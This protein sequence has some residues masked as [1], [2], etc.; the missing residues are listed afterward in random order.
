MVVFLL[1]LTSNVKAQQHYH[2]SKNDSIQISLLTCGPGEEVYSLYG[3]TAIRFHDLKNNQDLVVN[4]GMFSFSQRFFILRFVFGLTDYEMGIMPFDAFME[5]YDSEGRWVKEQILNIPLQDKM[6]IAMA[7]EKNYLP[8]NRT[9]RYN[10]FYD[11][12]TTRARDILI[13]NISGNVET[14]D[15]Q[16]ISS[17]YRKEIHKWNG[18]HCWARWGNDLLLGVNAD[19]S[20]D[21]K[22]QQFLPDNLSRDWQTAKIRYADGKVYNFISQEHY[23]IAKNKS[24]VENNA[25]DSNI[26]SPYYLIGVIIVIILLASWKKTKHPLP[27]KIVMWSVWLITGLCGIIITAMIFS[28]HP[29][30]SLNLQILLLNPLNLGMLVPALARN[31]KYNLT[32]L[33]CLVLFIFGG[34]IQSYADGLEYLAFILLIVSQR[35]LLSQLLKHKKQL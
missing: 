2:N 35:D 7:I 14:Q 11:N 18:D 22:E 26:F 4:Y 21:G 13:Q 20:I 30:V 29:T 31:K 8:E 19:R 34:I 27:Y 24:S 1:S 10:Y 3:H 32:I 33:T 5:E 16:K 12:C 17:S 23:L 15:N 9:Y 28:Q 25:V 6:K